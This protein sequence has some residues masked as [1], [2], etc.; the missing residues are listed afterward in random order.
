MSRCHDIWMFKIEYED[1]MISREFFDQLRI[2]GR[3]ASDFADL[4]L[5]TLEHYRVEWNA[6]WIDKIPKNLQTDTC[7]RMLSKLV[8]L[9]SPNDHL[10]WYAHTSMC[11]INYNSQGHHLCLEPGCV[12]CEKPHSRTVTIEGVSNQPHNNNAAFQE[13]VGRTCYPEAKTEE[14]RGMCKF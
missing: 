12:D 5:S 10:L 11:I 1:S 13:L 7:R 8:A 3:P 9:A 4:V 2:C 14:D 6:Q